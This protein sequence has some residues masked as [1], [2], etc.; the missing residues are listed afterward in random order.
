MSAPASTTAFDLDG[1][2]RAIEADDPAAQSAA[3]AP[4]AAVQTLN[5]DHG[6]AAPLVVRGRAALRELLDEV[7]ARGLTHEVVRAVAGPDTGALQIRCTYP[8]GLQV[9]C[10]SAFDHEGGLIVRET[11][12]EVWDG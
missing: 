12:L 2:V 4:D 9:L 5:R 7:A 11:R 1:L 8:D 3:Y 6:P 10:S